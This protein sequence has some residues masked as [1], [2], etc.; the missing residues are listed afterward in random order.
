MCAG[1]L[2]PS[3]HILPKGS[4]VLGP[5]PQLAAACPCSLWGRKFH[6]SGV[7]CF[8]MCFS[9]A[10]KTIDPERACTII[11]VQLN[12]MMSKAEQKQKKSHADVHSE[13]AC[14][15]PGATHIGQCT[16]S[17]IVLHRSNEEMQSNHCQ[18]PPA[19]PPMP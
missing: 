19:T 12:I 18:H 9:E 17:R 4:V 13:L 14:E 1:T 2:P 16:L 10:H 3:L 5:K 11:H 6:P 15:E 8:N 7:Q